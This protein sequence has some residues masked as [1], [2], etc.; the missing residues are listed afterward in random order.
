MV[1]ATAAAPNL[2]LAQ[3]GPLIVETTSGRVRG[4]MADAVVQFRGIPYGG[5]TSGRNRFMPPT[6]PAAWSG[7][8]DCVDWGHIAPQ[9]TNANPAAYDRMTGWFNFRGGMSEDCLALNVWTPAAD[10]KKRAVM[11]VLHGGGFHA[12]SGN[13]EALEGQFMAREGDL[14]VVT[15][16]HRLGPLGYLDLSDFGGPQLGQSGNAGMV[17]IAQALGWVHD[18]IER[19]GGDPAR[20]ALSGQSGGGGKVSTL[21]AMPSAAGLFHRAA[22]QSG[23]T[24]RVATREA[25]QRN[26]KALLDQL[27]VASGDLAKLQSLPFEQLTGARAAVGPVVD[28]AVLPRQPFDPDAP[29]ISA[30]VPLIIGT[31]LEDWGFSLPDRT[32]TEAALQAYAEAQAPGRGAEVVAAY[33]RLYPKKRPNLITAM[34]ATDIRTRANAALQAER[35]A[36]QHR[37][38]AYV[39]RYDFPIAGGD[40][41]WGAVHGSDISASM[42][43]PTTSMNLNTPGARLMSRC[44]GAAFIAFAKTGDPNTSAIPHWPA[45]DP[46]RRSTMVFDT[47]T[48]VVNDPDQELRL[49]WDRV[50]RP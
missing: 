19:F 5:D 50:G 45:Y 13:L 34:I 20:V 36:A 28:G 38:P 40:G 37:A 21:L 18:N 16:N 23:S 1:G 48:R 15:V 43:N 47:D 14:V 35:K 3:G 10:T 4:F 26:A 46:Q 49:M 17:D 30:D 27:G 32:N 22:I 12:G 9:P 42:S 44:I 2:V 25:A 41:Q 7:V 29:A 11:V 8:R 6:P 33:R 24:L 39:Y 31:C